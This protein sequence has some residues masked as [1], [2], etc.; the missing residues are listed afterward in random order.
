MNDL[1][2]MYYNQGCP[3]Y[4]MPGGANSENFQNS[5]R[6]VNF[7]FEIFSRR[8]FPGGLHPLPNTPLWAF[9]IITA[10]EAVIVP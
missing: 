3:D 1:E 5:R 8:N 9:L 2:I 7:Y 4:L 10:M 6:G